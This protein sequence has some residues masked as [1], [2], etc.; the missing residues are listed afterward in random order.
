MVGGCAAR[1]RGELAR[2]AQIFPER[3]NEALRAQQ[4]TKSRLA[5]EVGVTPST[6]SAWCGGR[7]LPRL[8][9]LTLLCEALR[10]APAYLLDAH[11]K[12]PEHLSC[13]A[14]EQEIVEYVRIEN[15]RLYYPTLSDIS[16]VFEAVDV[17]GAVV[18]LIQLGQLG[19]ETVRVLGPRP[20]NKAKNNPE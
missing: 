19:P 6:V 15:A 10:V 4:L 8:P 20:E 11:E 5:V 14:N 7:R 16:D 18:R 3:L 2:L 9:Q 17:A 1:E 13:S 12:L